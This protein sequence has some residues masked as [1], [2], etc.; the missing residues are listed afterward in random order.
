MAG[1]HLHFAGVVHAGCAEAVLELAG[2]KSMELGQLG[3]EFDARC[4]M[5][6]TLVGHSRYAFSGKMF[7]LNKTR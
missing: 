4:V 7:Q 1:T 6:L 2:V 5:I 3:I